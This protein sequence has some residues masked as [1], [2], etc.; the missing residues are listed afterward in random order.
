M[1]RFFL[2]LFSLSLTANAVD[3]FPAWGNIQGNFW[4][5]GLYHKVELANDGKTLAYQV[6]YTPL[7]CKEVKLAK[8]QCTYRYWVSAGNW[9]GKGE[10]ITSD[11]NGYECS[12]EPYQR[13]ELVTKS[14]ILFDDVDAFRKWHR[15]GKVSTY[16]DPKD[17]KAV[18]RQNPYAVSHADCMEYK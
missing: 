10:V 2:F 14:V 16:T 17:P 9:S 8:D 12:L 13:W 11:F 6:V 15:T 3:R 5:G 1:V 18:L 7:D 4:T